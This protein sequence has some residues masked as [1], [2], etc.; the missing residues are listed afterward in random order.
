MVILE[1]ENLFMDFYSSIHKYYDLIFPLKPNQ[2]NFI[3]E[4]FAPGTKILDIGCST[5]ELSL[6]L[7]KKSYQVYAIDLD[8]KMME[9]AISK[10]SNSN[11]IFKVAN[12]L[13]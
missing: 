4:E 13:D 8:S 10:N 7:A 5:G 11:P 3:T 9:L 12:M 6:Q 1:I 2:L